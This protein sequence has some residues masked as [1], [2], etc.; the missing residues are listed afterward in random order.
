M[1]SQA[2]AHRTHLSIY[3]YYGARRFDVQVQ[4]HYINK[5][6]NKCPP[7]TVPI[8]SNWKLRSFC[9]IIHVMFVAM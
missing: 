6:H 1:N 5:C 8:K 2:K 3:A 9:D 4:N 7:L